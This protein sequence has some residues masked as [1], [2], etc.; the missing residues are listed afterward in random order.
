MR[1]SVKI[2]PTV[3]R[4]V[5]IEMNFTLFVIF[6][7]V[8]HIAQGKRYLQY[9]VS[10]KQNRISEMFDTYSLFACFSPLW[11]RRSRFKDLTL[12]VDIKGEF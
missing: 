3:G 7:I 5:S 11:C 4:K 10:D 12:P 8:V 6:V 1:R 9:I 2:Q